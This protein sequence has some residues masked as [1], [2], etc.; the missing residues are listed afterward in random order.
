MTYITAV[1]DSIKV[2][3]DVN[4]TIQDYLDTEYRRGPTT[5]SQ[6]RFDNYVKLRSLAY[7]NPTE[8]NDAQVKINSGISELVSEGEQQL[9]DYID[10]CLNVKTRYPKE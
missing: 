10:N 9:E 2:N 3:I 6:W 8:L 5:V 7:P 4:L 1:W